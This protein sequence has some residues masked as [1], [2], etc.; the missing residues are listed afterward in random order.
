MSKKTTEENKTKE[1]LKNLETITEWFESR[2]D[3]DLDE[4]LKKL[5]EG[6]ELIKT[7]K[8]KVKYAENEFKEIKKSILE[9]E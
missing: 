9:D 6:A 3:V 7:L 2:E 1:L 5:K 8:E 4:A